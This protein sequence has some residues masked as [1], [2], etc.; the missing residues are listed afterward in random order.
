MKVL[1]KKLGRPCDTDA[2]ETRKILVK[3]ARRS[4]ADVGYDATTNR[5]LA[6]AAGITTGAIYHYFPSKL[7][8]YVAAYAEMQED[9]LSTFEKAAASH[10]TFT[11]KFSAILD[12]ILLVMLPSLKKVPTTCPK[13]YRRYQMPSP[14]HREEPSLYRR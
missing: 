5:A 13:L 14:L 6:L 3:E 10:E 1:A 11:D 7:E 9:V 4:F 12:S 8:M 2:G